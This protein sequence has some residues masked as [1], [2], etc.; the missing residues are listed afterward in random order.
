MSEILEVLS[1]HPFFEGLDPVYLRILAECAMHK[2][3]QQGDWIMLQ[4]GEANR[5]YL[6]QQGRVS[7]QFTSPS[8]GTVMVETLGDADIIGDSW[9]VE[10]YRWHWD[11][12]ALEYVR[13]IAFNAKCLRGICEEDHDI[14]YELMKR[15]SCIMVRYLQAARL[16]CSD[17]Y[18]LCGH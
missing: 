1:E 15:F 2:S 7:L 6:I 11:A 13:A 5:F 16:K 17:I 9:L 14:G 3:F 12:R 10:P 8:C 4:G 18:N